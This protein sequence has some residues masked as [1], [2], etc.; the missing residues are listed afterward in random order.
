MLNVISHFKLDFPFLKKWD[1]LVHPNRNTLAAGFI[2]LG[3]WLPSCFSGWRHNASCSH[4]RAGCSILKF[5]SIA[6]KYG[7][8]EENMKR[9]LKSIESK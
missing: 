3:V 7:S 8:G 6:N 4:S 2:H 5:W 1:I 9:T